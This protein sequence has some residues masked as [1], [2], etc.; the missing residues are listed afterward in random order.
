MN[1]R[2]LTVISPG[3]D[4]SLKASLLQANVKI[5]EQSCHSERTSLRK[6]CINLSSIAVKYPGLCVVFR[7]FCLEAGSWNPLNPNTVLKTPEG[8]GSK[9]R[10]REPSSAK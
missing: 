6:H 7:Y 8:C 9:F 3:T 4:S 10:K 5:S 2:D 1:L